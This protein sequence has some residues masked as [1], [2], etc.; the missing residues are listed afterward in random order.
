[1]YRDL[2][3]VGSKPRPHLHFTLSH[4]Q[5]KAMLT[6]TVVGVSHLPKGFRA[7]RDSYVK[8]YLLPKFAEPQ[9]TALQRRSLNP[10]FHEQFH[11]GCYRVE[12]LQDLTLRFAVYVK[13]FPNL[14]DSFIG[15]V[16]FPCAQAAW[17]QGSSFVYT[18][19]LSST[20]T[21]LKK[22]KEGIA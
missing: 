14:K 4:S 19:E 12:D 10:T 18:Q 20:K 9:R 3:S 8:V 22:V 5:L 7:S 2:Y 11:F 6:V 21:K 1:M 15:E 13:E 16:M 17:N